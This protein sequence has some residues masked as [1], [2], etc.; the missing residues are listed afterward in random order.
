VKRVF[1]IV[2]VLSLVV[3]LG[4]ASAAPIT[5]VQAPISVEVTNPIAWE[6]SD[7]IIQF[8]NAQLLL[9]PADYIDIMF[10]TDTDLGTV[11]S[12]NVTTPAITTTY[13]VI[14]NSLRIRLADGEAIEGGADV[15]IVV[16][17]VT[18]PGPC[19][20]ILC[21]GTS[22]ASQVCS[23]ESEPE[24]LATH[25]LTMAADSADGG[26]ATDVTGES[27]YRAGAVVGIRAEAT[28]GYRFVKWTAA[29][30]VVFEDAGSAETT[31]VMPDEEVTVTARFESI[32]SCTLTMASDP[33]EGGVAS[34]ENGTGTYEAGAAVAIEAVAASGYR[35]VKWTAAPEVEF[36]DAGSAETTFVMPDEAV[37]ITASF[38]AVRELTISST[39]GGRVTAPGEGEFIYDAGEPVGLAAEADYGYDFVKWTGSVDA[40]ADPESASTTIIV[41]GDYSLTASFEETPPVG[42]GCF[43]ATA[44][45]GTPG[46][47]QIDVLREFRDVVLM[48]SEAGS[49]FVTWYYRTSPAIAEFLAGSELLRTFTGEFLVNPVVWMVEATATMWQAS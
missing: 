48:E 39:S 22:T 25:K 17:G 23:D 38:V 13:T 20:H 16:A 34:A 10:P 11:T 9:G 47:E 37:T 5:A 33:V 45:Y 2:V 36:E 43:I 15:A 26:T 14:G 24:V 19:T 46:A 31:F 4:L 40:I 7:Y 32:P 28:A 6:L 21:V 27:P 12:V 1:A 41:D 18:N 42:T 30:E 49:R 35:F 8:K 44:V 3:V 29:P